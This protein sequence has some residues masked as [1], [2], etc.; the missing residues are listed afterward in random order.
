MGRVGKKD[1]AK[2]W[3]SLSGIYYI[4]MICHIEGKSLASF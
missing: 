2:A 3:W 1:A 4:L